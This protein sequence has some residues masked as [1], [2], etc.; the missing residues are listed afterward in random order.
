MYS[1]GSLHC[2]QHLMEHSS[3]H[4]GAKEAAAFNGRMSLSSRALLTMHFHFRTLFFPIFKKYVAYKREGGQLK[5]CQNNILFR[6]DFFPYKKGK[7]IEL[8]VGG[9]KHTYFY[10]IVFT[11][12]S[13]STRWK[14]PSRH[15][16]LVWTHMLPSNTTNRQ[17]KS[18]ITKIQGKLMNYCSKYVISFSLSLDKK[19]RIHV[20]LYI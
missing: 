8:G 4:S 3:E 17:G 5:H 1:C 13:D 7:K 10:L 16:A 20:F 15:N 18:P 19:V 12:I 11:N 2:P 14:H 6:E 9:H